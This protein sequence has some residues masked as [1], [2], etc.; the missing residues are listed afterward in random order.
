MGFYFRKR[1]SFGPLSLNLTKSGIGISTGIRGLRAGVTS[2]GKLFTSA[3]VPGTG[4][5]YRRYYGHH[6]SSEPS[7]FQIGF[8]VGLALPFVLALVLALWSLR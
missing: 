8:I 5:Y 4:M 2:H 7:S 6:H 1:R 3:N